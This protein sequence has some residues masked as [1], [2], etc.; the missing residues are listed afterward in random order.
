MDALKLSPN[1]EKVVG[2]I[3][4]RP[5]YAGFDVIGAGLPR[6]GTMSMKAALGIL[7][8][9]ACYHLTDV[10]S[11]QEVDLVH[12]EKSISC[13]NIKKS[14]W[15]NFLEGRGFR[16]GVDF[17]IALFYRYLLCSQHVLTFPVFLIFIRFDLIYSIHL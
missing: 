10:A 3:H 5:N 9:G 15:V 1:F 16:S 11:S 8:N 13:Q 17:P 2:S 14:E 6:T 12:W 4:Q 7:L